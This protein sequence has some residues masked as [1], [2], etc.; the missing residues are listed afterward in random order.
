MGFEAPSLWRWTLARRGWKTVGFVVGD[1]AEMA[2]RRFY[3][4][5]VNR[6]VEPMA[7]AA[8]ASAPPAPQFA[9]PVRRG[10]PS[11]H[12]VIGLFP[13]PGGQR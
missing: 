10:P 13:E 2:E 6:A 8:P 5:W 4:E 11:G 9:T 7:S 1:K 3:A 12:D